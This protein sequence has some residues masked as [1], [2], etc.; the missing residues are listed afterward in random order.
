MGEIRP[1]GIRIEDGSATLIK[2][3][4]LLLAEKEDAAQDEFGNAIGMH[5]G[6][7]KGEGR[8]PGSAEYLPM[9]NAEVF[10]EFLDIGDKIPG[11]IGFKGR[12]R[13]ALAASALIKDDDVVFL[14]VKSAAL[15][16]IGTA[17]WTTMQK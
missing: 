16:R 2:P 14:R 8:T 4:D 6:I 17:A 15:F 5:F 3:V 13:C 11:G 9:L 12:I 10:A 7:S 1:P